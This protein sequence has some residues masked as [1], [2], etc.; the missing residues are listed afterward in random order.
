M[1]ADL[2][3]RSEFAALRERSSVSGPH[4]SPNGVVQQPYLC[5]DPDR[6]D[7]LDLALGL[8]ANLASTLVLSLG[9]F[10]ALNNEGVRAT[11]WSPVVQM[12]GTF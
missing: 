6:H 1:S 11:Q 9:V 7:Y 10:K 3:G 4:V 5:L 12:E 2:L 8:R